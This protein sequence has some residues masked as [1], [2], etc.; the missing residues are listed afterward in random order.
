ME[1]RLMSIALAWSDFKGYVAAIGPGRGRPARPPHCVFCE[2]ARVWFNGW[3]LVWITLLVE[4]QPQRPAEGL[5]LQRVRCARRECGHS[6][7][8]RPPWT[9]PGFVDSRERSRRAI[10]RRGLAVLARGA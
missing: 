4:G 1:E 7:T 10:S 5:P 3:R 6:W 9:C 8:L 2:G